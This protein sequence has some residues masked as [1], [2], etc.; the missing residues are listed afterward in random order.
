MLALL[1]GRFTQGFVNGGR[2]SARLPSLTT[3]T[4]TVFVVSFASGVH[5]TFRA[6]RDAVQSGH[7][8]LRHEH[9][10]LWRSQVQP[11]APESQECQRAANRSMSGRKFSI[12]SSRHSFVVETADALHE[13]QL[14]AL[15]LSA[16]TLAV[17]ALI[18]VARFRVVDSCLCEPQTEEDLKLAAACHEK[19]PNSA[20]L[21]EFL[22][23]FPAQCVLRRSSIGNPGFA[24]SVVSYNKHQER[25]NG[26]RQV[27]LC[28]VLVSFVLTP[29]VINFTDQKFTSARLGPRGEVV[30]EAHSLFQSPSRNTL[31]EGSLNVS[32]SKSSKSKL[33]NR[34]SAASAPEAVQR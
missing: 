4:A 21:R 31:P 17:M 6:L 1:H 23:P 20:L 19:R 26:T 2:P 7:H 15:P 14:F 10:C 29:M 33:C 12:V 28:I 24:G 22:W 9:R 30:C 16:R 5:R 32:I 27:K 13:R 11:L 25:P 3:H 18:A 34:T 8:H